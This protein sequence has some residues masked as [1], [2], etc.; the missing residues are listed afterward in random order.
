MARFR[1]AVRAAGV[2]ILVLAGCGGPKFNPVSGQL[3]FPDGTPVRGAKGTGVTFEGKTADGKGYSASGILDDEGRFQLTTEQP[4]DGAIAGKCKVIIVPAGLGQDRPPPKVIDT[5]YESLD[6][7]P[8]EYEVKP[9][10]N[11]NVTLTVEPF[12]NR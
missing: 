11:E 1:D 12:K 9:G 7:T 4:G 6:T 10:A 8:L 2:L 3:V 5:K